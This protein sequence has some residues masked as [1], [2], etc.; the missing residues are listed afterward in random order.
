MKLLRGLGKIPYNQRKEMC[1]ISCEWKFYNDE[2]TL[3]VYY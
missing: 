1:A 3:L 2:T